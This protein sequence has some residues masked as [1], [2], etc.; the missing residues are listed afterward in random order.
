[1][2]TSREF[3]SS[4]IGELQQNL[5]VA[6]TRLKHRANEQGFSA[7]TEKSEKNT[8]LFF[9]FGVGQ[10]NFLVESTCSCEVFAEAAVAPVP[11]A[12]ECMLGLFNVRGSLIPVYQLHSSLEVPFPKKKCI[13]VV[14]K[15]ERAIGLLI[16][17]LP[18]SL[19][20]P[21]E[22]KMENSDAPHLVL[23][24]LT[25]THFFHAAKSWWLLSGKTLPENLL[26]MAHRFLKSKALVRT[27]PDCVSV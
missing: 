7:E 25:N 1:M 12:P 27:T 14:G 8:E 11:N 9:S 20:M 16:D 10:H 19:A 22:S 23:Q 5:V 6:L 13:F 24:Q 15:A 2:D 26:A 3:A 21:E 18:V 17:S 4:D